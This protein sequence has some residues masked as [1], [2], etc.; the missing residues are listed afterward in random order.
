MNERAGEHRFSR[1]VLWL[2]GLG[3]ADGLIWLGVW[4][5]TG[6]PTRFYRFFR[7]EGA[8]VL[9]ACPLAEAWFAARIQRS[10]APDQTMHRAWRVILV[11][12]ACAFTGGILAQI[13]GVESPLN[14]LFTA[15]KWSQEGGAELRNWGLFLA[16][17][18]Q[19]IALAIGLAW[20]LRTYREAGFNPRLAAGDKALLIAVALYILSEAWPLAAAL[21]HGKRATWFEILNWP[22]DPV[23]W[24]LL[25]Q[26]MLLRRA[27]RQTGMGL[28][29]KCWLAF[30]AGI[31]LTVAGDVG[32]W[33]TTYGFLPWPWSSATW[34]VW[35]P[36][37]AAFALGPAYQFEAVRSARKMP[38]FRAA[39]R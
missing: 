21:R 30:S 2:A 3:M 25:A 9:V 35:I 26:A 10:F 27:V 32:T 14:P 6:D 17:P 19:F 12:A 4:M 5:A 11:S 34:F 22:V 33:A 13:L 15:G 36:A 16:G 20:A 8:L 37:S 38:S 7:R 23:L 31:G 24:V 29:G 28:V 18:C 1:A 39:A